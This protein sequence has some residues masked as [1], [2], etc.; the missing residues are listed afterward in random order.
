M[1]DPES[2]INQSLNDDIENIK[3]IKHTYQQIIGNHDLFIYN[4]I[5]RN[6]C[7]NIP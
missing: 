1:S 3:E 2:S 6:G 4:D 7:N 5:L